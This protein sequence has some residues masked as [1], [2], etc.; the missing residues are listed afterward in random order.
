MKTKHLLAMFL[1]VALSMGLTSC[2]EIP[3][4]DSGVMGDVKWVYDFDAETLTFS[5]TGEITFRGEEDYQRYSGMTDA[6]IINEGITGIGEDAFY[7]FTTL[8][9][10]SI[11]NSVTYIG[12]S[13]FN[14]CENLYAVSIPNSVE[15]IGDNAF[16]E[17]SVLNVV[18]IGDGVVSIGDHAF[19]ECYNLSS[20]TIGRSVTHIDDYAFHKGYSDNPSSLKTVTCKAIIPP[21]FGTFSAFDSP[22]S[23]DLFVPKESISAYKEAKTWKEFRSISP[24][25]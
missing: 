24:I 16:Y 6:V 15:R 25:K 3:K 23:V 10:V 8:K 2:L 17:C 21:T 11:P 12:R 20:V 14:W 5:G 4:T 13:A 9:S 18:I 1:T 7:H 19:S 22:G